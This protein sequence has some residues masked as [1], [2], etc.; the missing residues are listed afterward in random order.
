M[1]H[2]DDVDFSQDRHEVC[3][4]PRVRTHPE[5]DAEGDA[6][7]GSSP[8]PV[9]A[10]SPDEEF[11]W[12]RN[13]DSTYA[14]EQRAW[15]PPRF[16]EPKE[17]TSRRRPPLEVRDWGRF[18]D[19]DGSWC[20]ARELMEPE[21]NHGRKKRNLFSSS[22]GDISWGPVSYSVETDFA[23]SERWTIWEPRAENQRAERRERLANWLPLML[24]VSPAWDVRG[25][26]KKE[27]SRALKRYQK[28]TGR[29]KVVFY[30]AVWGLTQEEIA[31]QYGGSQGIP[32]SPKTVATIIQEEERKMESVLDKLDR[33]LDT[34]DHKEA[35]D[36]ERW[37]QLLQA[38][39]KDDN[40][41]PDLRLIEGGKIAA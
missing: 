36:A 11:W 10:N 3:G 1:N 30:Y 21:R 29:W 22:K 12:L 16:K 9:P 34:L 5:T 2:H 17:W 31:A 14:A 4:E 7:A 25:S 27:W 33:V 26:T 39:S 19:V 40:E 28:T 23:T 20:D 38:L 37:H 13:R 32:R 15:N 18:P 24:S 6:G 8:G 41:R 35:M